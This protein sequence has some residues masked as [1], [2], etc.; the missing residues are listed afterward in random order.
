MKSLL[1]VLRVGYPWLALDLARLLRLGV[2]SQG[3]NVLFTRKRLS[4]GDLSLLKP[5]KCQAIPLYREAVLANNPFFSHEDRKLSSAQA[6]RS[7]TTFSTGTTLLLGL[8]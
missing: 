1:W 6:S 7:M 4:F 2:I 5:M 3:F 8:S